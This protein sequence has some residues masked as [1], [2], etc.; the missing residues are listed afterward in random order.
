M[1]NNIRSLVVDDSGLRQDPNRIPE[2]VALFNRDGSVFSGGGGSSF[3]GVELKNDGTATVADYAIG[4]G[5]ADGQYALVEAQSDCAAWGKADSNNGQPASLES[6]GE[7]C[8]VAGY[9]YSYNH[10]AVMRATQASSV[11]GY[12]SDSTMQAT[13]WGA[14]VSGHAAA[15]STIEAPKEGAII[16]GQAKDGG[17]LKTASGFGDSTGAIFGYARGNATLGDD[18][19]GY[20]W[21]R[22]ILVGGAALG[23]N[24]A[25]P[26]THTALIHGGYNGAIS[27]GYAKAGTATAEGNA[28]IQAYGYGAL[29]MGHCTGDWAEDPGFGDG[30]IKARRHGSM[31]HGQVDR[32]GELYANAWGSHAFGQVEDGARITTTGRG[33]MA[34]G[35]AR[36]HDSLIEAAGSGSSAFGS[37]NDGGIIRALTG[38]GNMAIGYAGPGETIEVTGNSAMQLGAG[39]NDTDTSLRIGGTNGLHFHGGGAPASPAN[40]D[41]WCDGTDVFVRTGGATKNI[42]SLT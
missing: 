26:T 21:G 19:S 7:G 9:A 34:S 39:T 38:Q 36:D 24:G 8:L 30:L 14:F 13:G 37:A 25:N 42:T 20:H 12:A 31:A 28:E 15:N 41:M 16:V 29:A 17:T 23:I 11:H 32:G 1:A 5:E 22:G 27:W 2:T 3:N 33:A 40:G 18:G 6:E 35:R 4:F 10:T